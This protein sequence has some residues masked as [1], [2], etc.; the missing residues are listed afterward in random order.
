MMIIVFTGSLHF[1]IDNVLACSAADCPEDESPALTSIPHA[2]WSVLVSMSTV[3]YGDVTP[4]AGIGKLLACLQIIMEMYYMAMPLSIVG[5]NFSDI[6]KDRHRLLFRYRTSKGVNSSKDL[7]ETFLDFDADSSGTI[8]MDEFIG[9][10]TSLNMGLSKT[11]VCDLYNCIDRD[12]SGLITLVEF[13]RVCVS[14]QTF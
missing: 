5:N 11:D 8:T 3:G 7:K 6:R 12:G 9:P 2:M 10:I 1:W 14:I 4:R 13:R